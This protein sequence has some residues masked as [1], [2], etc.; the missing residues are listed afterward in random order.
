MELRRLEALQNLSG[1]GTS[2]VIFDLAKPYGD[3][4]AEAAGIAAALSG[5]ESAKMRVAK[6]PATEEERPELERSASRSLGSK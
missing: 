2:K 6:P 4:H 1:T 3:I 5:T